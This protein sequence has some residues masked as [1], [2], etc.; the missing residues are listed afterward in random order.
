MRWQLQCPF[1]SLALYHTSRERREKTGQKSYGFSSEPRNIS[2][3]FWLI[4][5]LSRGWQPFQKVYVLKVYVL[6][7]RL[8]L[9]WDL[10]GHHSV[11]SVHVVFPQVF[12]CSFTGLFRNENAE[13]TQSLSCS[14]FT[15][16]CWKNFAPKFARPNWKIHAVQNLSGSRI[17][18]TDAQGLFKLPHLLS[19][20]VLFEILVTMTPEQKISLTLNSSKLPP[21]LLNVYFWGDKAY[22]WEIRS[23]LGDSRRI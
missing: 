23:T 2:I 12:V 8:T 9:G 17:T 22:F 13:F 4:G 10:S 5:W 21:K 11:F 1:W 15:L 18:W 7:S 20:E 16:D 14:L 3:V 6:F 19:L